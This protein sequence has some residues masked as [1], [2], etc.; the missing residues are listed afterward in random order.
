MA[1]QS[2]VLP[3]GHTLGNRHDQRAKQA[4]REVPGDA[5]SPIHYLRGS[6]NLEKGPLP[7]SQCG[8]RRHRGTTDKKAA[9]QLQE[10]CQEMRTH[11]YTTFVD[12]KKAFDTV[13]RDGL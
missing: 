6:N 1:K 10:K 11:L 2:W 3:S 12:M 13:N 7:E 8:F 4:T 9:R 5:N